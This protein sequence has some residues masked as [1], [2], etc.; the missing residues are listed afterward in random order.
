MDKGTFDWLTRIE[1][2]LDYIITA[3]QPKTEPEKKEEKKTI[4]QRPTKEE[5]E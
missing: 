3:M 4:E 1:T 5:S 2:K